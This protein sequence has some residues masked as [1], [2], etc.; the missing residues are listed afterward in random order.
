MTKTYL[1][2]AIPGALVGPAGAV[3]V[4]QPVCPEE[5]G[6]AVRD[7]ACLSAIGHAD[8]AALVGKMVGAHVPMARISV[9]ALAHGDVHYL[10]LYQGPRL[11]EGSTSLPEGAAVAF[12]RL[13]AADPAQA[14]ANL[15]Y[16]ADYPVAGGDFLRAMMI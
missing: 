4:I 7:G 14:Q 11:P 15:A 10:A 1:L 13:S 6:A 5:I 9:P 3:L 8:T 12:F 2:N 16:E